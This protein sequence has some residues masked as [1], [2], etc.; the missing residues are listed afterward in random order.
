[1]TDDQVQRAVWREIKR[2][3]ITFNDMISPAN[4]GVDPNPEDEYEGNMKRVRPNRFKED[5]GSE[6]I[7]EILCHGR[8]N[9]YDPYPPLKIPFND[10]FRFWWNQCVEKELV[11]DEV[12]GDIY[13]F[14]L[15]EMRP[16]QAEDLEMDIALNFDQI[17][18]F[19]GESEHAA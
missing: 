19:T 1:M 5:L 15:E 8:Y 6:R 11:V 14:F 16:K 7:K 12:L 10:L 2:R 9:P 4:H 13:D 18:I 17:S 3:G